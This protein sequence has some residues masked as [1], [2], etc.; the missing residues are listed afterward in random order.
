MSGGKNF[1]PLTLSP[2]KTTG[3]KRS[4]RLDEKFGDRWGGIPQSLLLHTRTT[5]CEP[6]G[7]DISSTG[8]EPKNHSPTRRTSGNVITMRVIQTIQR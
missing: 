2:K 5:E 4:I 7:M 8:T 1:I 6:T 3:R